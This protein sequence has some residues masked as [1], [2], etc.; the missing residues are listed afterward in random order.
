MNHPNWFQ[1]KP[2]RSTRE[3]TV[4]MPKALT[5]TEKAKDIMKQLNISGEIIFRGQQKAGQFAF[6]TMRP[7]ERF[8]VNITLQNNIAKVNRVKAQPIATL[9]ILHTFSGIRGIW[10]ES[11]SQRDWLPTRIWSF[12]MDALCVGL[13]LIVV[14]S[15][16]LDNVNLTLE[17]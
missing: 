5:N 6:I 1:H 13:I 10:R 14:S 3:Q 12:S 17:D 15:L 9:E 7:N 16:Y 2:E 8:F 11:D 4:Q